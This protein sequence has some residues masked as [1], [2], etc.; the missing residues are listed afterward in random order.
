MYIWL[1]CVSCFQFS[2]WKK[3]R[4]IYKPHSWYRRRAILVL[5][6]RLN[7]RRTSFFNHQLHGISNHKY[8]YFCNAN[9]F[10]FISQSTHR[11]WT[12][13]AVN[14]FLFL[15]FFDVQT[16]NCSVYN[17]SGLICIYAYALAVRTN[18]SRCDNLCALFSTSMNT[19][20][21]FDMFS[22]RWNQIERERKK[23][24]YRKSDCIKFEYLS[25]FHTEIENVDCA[26]NEFKCEEITCDKMTKI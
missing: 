10:S 3:N 12:F 9:S 11:K 22:Q 18:F 23:E 7:V 8:P 21:T 4:K 24:E 17:S 5:C 19:H 26:E 13:T 1:L 14:S 2:I 6:E 15:S 25:L 16:A 20:H